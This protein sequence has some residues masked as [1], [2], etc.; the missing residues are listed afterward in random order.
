RAAQNVSVNAE[1]L[2]VKIL[3]DATDRL[4]AGDPEAGQYG[5]QP[6]IDTLR[7]M[8][9][10]KVQAGEGVRML[11]ALGAGGRKA[12]EKQSYASVLLFKWG[13]QVLPVF[14]T[15]VQLEIK[16]HLPGLVP[17]RAEATLNLQLIESKND[18]YVEELQR[19]FDASMRFVRASKDATGVSTG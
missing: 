6:E 16:D 11:A 8:L 10:P 17:Y 1:T 13:V 12:F 3:L 14:L 4:N 15:Q 18:F 5:V 2:S 19:Q 7:S 9:E